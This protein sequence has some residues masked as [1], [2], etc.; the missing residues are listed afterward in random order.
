MP[1]S[2]ARNDD[3]AQGGILGG[4]RTLNVRISTD[5]IAGRCHACSVTRRAWL[6]LLALGVIWGIPY[7]FIRIAVT[8]VDPLVVAGGRTLIGALI[9]LPFALHRR[10]LR[11][12]LRKWPAVLA[13]TVFE[14][15]GPWLL[16]G[17]AEQRVTS[18]TAA[19]FIA[20]VPIV[21]A[22]LA[23]AT[24]HERFTVLRGLGLVVGLAGVVLLVGLD[25]GVADPFAVVALALTVVGYSVAPMIMS[26]WLSD[27]SNVG[28]IAL[29][30]TMATLI[31]LPFVPF[32]TPIEFT[33]ASATSVAVLG[34]V[35]TALAFLIFF[36]LIRTVG[37]SRSVLVAY[38]NP[39][40][41]VL[42]GVL[43]LA[44]PFTLGIALG[45]PLVIL[46]SVMASS[47][48]R[49]PAPTPEAVAIP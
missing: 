19:L 46:G 17:H 10:A 14:I 2:V 7:L 35:C 38:L 6:L 29:S 1:P 32:V 27:V 21:T 26:R 44:E 47:R 20:A 43:I 11:A 9:L 30:L 48:P 22:A 8:D 25:V 15:T 49:D 36:E 4:S 23:F 24:R 39:G 40:V 13:F 42:L 28:V 16:I 45:L 18:S 5:D 37:P 3:S 31:Y 12:A 33:A 34:V 41:A